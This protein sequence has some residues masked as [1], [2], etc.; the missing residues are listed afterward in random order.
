MITLIGW[1]TIAV[2]VTI[3]LLLLLGWLLGLFSWDG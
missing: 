1:V 2:V 3:V